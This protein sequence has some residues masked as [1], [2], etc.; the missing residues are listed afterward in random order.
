MA[1]IFKTFQYA[2]LYL[3]FISLQAWPNTGKS[4][5]QNSDD[6]FNW[7]NTNEK[8]FTQCQI[9]EEGDF[10]KLCDETLVNKAELKKLFKLSPS[11][12]VKELKSKN[13][14]IEI[15]CD[16]KGTQPFG[17]VC[18]KSST[19]KSFEKLSHLHGQYLPEQDLILIKSTASTGS[20]IHEYIHRLQSQN[21]RPIKG[22]VYK[23]KRKQIQAGLVKLMDDKIALIQVLEK[24]KNMQEIQKHLPEFSAAANQMH[25]FSP[26][27]DLIDERSIFLLFIKYQKDLGVDQADLELAKKNM[28]FICQRKE[29]QNKLPKD[30]CD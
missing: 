8:H 25:K 26:W 17:S 1:P 24:N 13:A 5:V 21:Q 6:F 27:Q 30:Q 10:Y 22:V 16:N 3:V 28:G 23:Q 7:L 9:T 4:A 12:L 20:L 11:E 29:W 2:L 18:V 19:Q 15:L 14:K